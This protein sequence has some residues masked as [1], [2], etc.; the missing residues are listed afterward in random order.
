MW[1]VSRVEV[2]GSTN[3]DVVAAAKEGEPEGYVLVADQQTAGKGR[4]GRSWESPPG[5]SMSMSCLLRPTD[6]PASKWPWLPL[7]LGVTVAEAVRD[8]TGV[9]VRLKWPNDVLI[10][11][12]KLAGILVERTET[13]IGPAAVAGVGM[14]ITAAPPG[15]ASLLDHVHSTTRS[16]VAN[17]HDHGERVLEELLARL[18]GRYRVWRADPAATELADDYLGWC[19]TLG[20]D[21]QAL[22]P[23]GGELSGRAVDIDDSGRLVIASDGGR[24]AIGA[25]DI[26]HLRPSTT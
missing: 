3:G 20:R 2:T 5:T 24:Q 14:N 18:A 6:V 16:G 11:G 21:V 4:L 8:A 22:L 23:G 17:G 7:L 12:A 13:P 15:A 9:T 1:R 19:D 25:G 10:G 26:V